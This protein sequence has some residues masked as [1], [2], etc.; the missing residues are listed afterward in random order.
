MKLQGYS[1]LLQQVVSGSIP[2]ITNNSNELILLTG[3]FWGLHV[4]IKVIQVNITCQWEY[5][6]YEAMFT[7][8][9]IANYRLLS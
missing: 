3:P 6:L 5:L 4:Q 8:N 1:V 7:A 9:I 2:C